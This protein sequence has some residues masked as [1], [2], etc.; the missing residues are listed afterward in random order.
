MDLCGR[1]GDFLHV[2]LLGVEVFEVIV[3]V[4]GKEGDMRNDFEE[5]EAI[6]TNPPEFGL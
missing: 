3:P 1:G 6:L 4:E 2:L 5:R